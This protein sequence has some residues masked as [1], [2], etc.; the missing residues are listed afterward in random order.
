[1]LT[2]QQ[3][4]NNSFSSDTREFRTMI[5][6]MS[7]SINPIRNEIANPK[8]LRE[9]YV[10]EYFNEGCRRVDIRTPV[11]RGLGGQR[12]GGTV[13]WAPDRTPEEMVAVAAYVQ[14]K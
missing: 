11:D 14:S 10:R 5:Q 2:E 8:R 13:I 4:G 9:A 7:D 3:I 6:I 1:M 12:R